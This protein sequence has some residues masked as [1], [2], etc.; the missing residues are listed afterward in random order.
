MLP[1][2]AYISLVIPPEDRL[3]LATGLVCIGVTIAYFMVKAILY[4]AERESGA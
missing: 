1:D 4:T 2:H 3:L